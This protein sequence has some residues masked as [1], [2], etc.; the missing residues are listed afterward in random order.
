M[1]L[2][3]V[4]TLHSRIPKGARSWK[5]RSTS[6]SARSLLDLLRVVRQGVRAGVDSYSLKDI[7]KLFFERRAEVSSGNEAVIE[8]ERWLDDVTPAPDVMGIMLLY[9]HPR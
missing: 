3:S 2:T 8:F 1:L 9:V 6:S 5:R 7:Q 4:R